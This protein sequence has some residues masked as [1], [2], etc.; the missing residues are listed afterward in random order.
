M[1]TLV[2]VALDGTVVWKWEHRHRLPLN[3]QQ[4]PKFPGEPLECHHTNSLYWDLDTNVVYLNPRNMYTFYAVNK[5]DGR[6]LWGVG[7]A[8][9]IQ[10]EA[11]DGWGP[12]TWWHGLEPIGQDRFVAFNNNGSNNRSSAVV[13]QLQRPPTGPATARLLW[14]VFVRDWVKWMGD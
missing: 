13:W 7:D 4:C 12:R 11:D 14:R 6:V 3:L 5:S 8:G 10:L 9:D 2:E 1:D